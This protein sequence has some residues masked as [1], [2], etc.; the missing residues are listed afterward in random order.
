MKFSKT[1]P[2]FNDP[3]LF[4]H[5]N[6][7]TEEGQDSLN[8]GMLGLDL[9]SNVNF[10]NR[11]EERCSG[12]SRDRVIGRHCFLDVAPCMNNFLVAER[13]E[14]ERPLNAIIPYVL[15]F[16]MRPTNV[17]LR[18]LCAMEISQRWILISRD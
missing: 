13:V 12:L 14:H 2:G 6:E 11:Y 7:L 18:M 9:Q 4:E 8:F 3:D 10:Y 1:V 5:L 17:R 15:T 16:R